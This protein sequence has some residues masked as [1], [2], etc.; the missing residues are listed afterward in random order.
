[1]S[2]INQMLNDLD[3]RHATSG[4][5]QP[6]FGDVRSRR[7]LGS[8]AFIWVL[9]AL[10]AGFGAFAWSQLSKPRAPAPAAPMSTS[11]TMTHPAQPPAEIQQVAKPEGAEIPKVAEIKQTETKPVV[12][13][14][15]EN[16]T[17]NVSKAPAVSAPKKSGPKTKT[18]NKPTGGTESSFKV[19]SPQQ[20]SDNLYLQAILFMQQ[21]R[22]ADAQETLKKSL[23]ANP[24]NQNARQLLAILLAD[25]GRNKEAEELLQDGLDISPGNSDFSIKL[26]RLQVDDGAKEKAL[27]TLEK[28]L[29]A[30]G[31]HDEYHAF[32]A[33]L[34]QGQGRHNEAVQHY[35]TALRSNPSNPHW[36]IGAGISLRA[37]NKTSDAAEAFQRALDT[38]E[39]SKEVAEFAEQ[40]LKQLRPLR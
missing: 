25:A 37:I 24:S 19:V 20:Q 33:A 14:A 12:A 18:R 8:P 23:G 5:K 4:G 13:M 2:L 34:L 11:E 7:R 26:A 29:P 40:Q 32:L 36:L 3:K 16:T 31:N 38:G 28:G 22:D 27:A 15:N 9:V 30:A 1:M 10:A 6:L 17:G 35:I 21:S 39:L